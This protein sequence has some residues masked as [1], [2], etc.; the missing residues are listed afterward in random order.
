MQ[1]REEGE[2]EGGGG[3][4][5]TKGGTPNKRREGQH[6]K[7]LAM[8][9]AVATAT[10]I[11]Q[12]SRCRKQTRQTMRQTALKRRRYE[13]GARN[14]EETASTQD[15]RGR[16]KSTNTR[17]PKIKRNEKRQ[18]VAVYVVAA[19][20]QAPRAKTN[21]SAKKPPRA[22][23]QERTR[24]EERERGNNTGAHIAVSSALSTQVNQPGSPSSRA[25]SG[26]T[27]SSSSSPFC[28]FRLKLKRCASPRSLLVAEYPLQRIERL[29]FLL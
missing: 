8:T 1:K 4:D 17:N 25:K 7:T 13:R 15:A 26:R 10:A 12:D 19:K 20:R 27:R 29:P 21:T 16:S 11:R 6:G 9:L 2:V 22:K 24:R 28:V 23:S 18:A 14:D 5:G 3:R